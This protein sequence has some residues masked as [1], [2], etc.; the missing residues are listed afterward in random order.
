MKRVNLGALLACLGVLLFVMFA[1][2]FAGAASTASAESQRRSV[3]WQVRSSRDE[4]LVSKALRMLEQGYFMEIDSEH[5]K[6]L[7]YGALNGMFSELRKD[8]YKDEFSHFYDPELYDD[9]QAQT[10]GEY[11]GIGILMGSTPDGMYPEVVTVFPNTPAEEQGLEASD[12][13]IQIEGE[14][15][16][17]MILPAVASKIKGKPGSTV[18]L[19][20]YRPAD[21]EFYS[22]EITRREVTYSTIAKQELLAG[23]VGYIKISNFAEETGG[24]FRNAMEALTA[25]GMKSLVIDL[26]DDTGGVLNAAVDVADCFVRDGL[27]VEIDYRGQ[28]DKPFPADPKSEKYSLPIVVLVN[29]NT[30]SASEV[31]ASCL[32]DYGLAK[33][34]G[35]KTFGK[36][37]VQ[38]VVPLE[39]GVVETQAPDGKTYKADKVIS[40]VAITVGK[41]YTKSRTEIHGTGLAPDIWFDINNRLQ[42]EPELQAFDEKIKAKRNELI[43]IRA[44]E[45]RYVRSNDAEKGKAVDVAAKLGRGESVPDA[46]QVKPKEE[47]HSGLLGS[48]APRSESPA[49][50]EQ[51]KP[52][53]GGG[54]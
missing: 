27:I 9:L 34:V 28:A 8:P 25:K 22:R 44:Q 53:Q 41:Y 7:I 49:G 6:Q 35:E 11:A 47:D 38:E 33:L 43:S 20:L 45:M 29:A 48:V 54:K 24:D 5:E 18:K 14:D 52:A 21:A 17:A 31:L 42:N 12:V 13:I 16:F 39:K 19:K 15:T 51:G 3:L 10:T 32:R 1:A 30:A 46:P 50:K 26:R 2:Y 4:A 40:A 36:G 23:G 37:V